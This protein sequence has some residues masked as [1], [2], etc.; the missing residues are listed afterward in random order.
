MSTGYENTL[1]ITAKLYKDLESTK[2]GHP[3]LRLVHNPNDSDD[4]TVWIDAL[5]CQEKIKLEV[6]SL[7]LQ[8]FDIVTVEGK[9][10]PPRVWK[11]KAYFSIFL[12]KISKWEE[13]VDEVSKQEEETSEEDIPF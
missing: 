6:D 11:D 2:N 10:N 7:S 13:P 1:K 5:A 12:N 4:D 8:K 3:K 9:L